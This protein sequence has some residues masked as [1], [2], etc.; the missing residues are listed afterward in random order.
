[1]KRF[2]ELINECNI[3]SIRHYI[4]KI[5]YLNKTK[6]KE[7]MDWYKE[8]SK[9]QPT[10]S[11]N[12]IYIKKMHNGYN[13]SFIE[14][15]DPDD[16]NELISFSVETIMFSDLFGMYAYNDKLKNEE[17]VVAVLR[18]NT[19]SGLYDENKKAFFGELENLMQ[20]RFKNIQNKI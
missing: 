6:L 15:D 20:E 5:F 7:Y 1:M 18:E 10:L 13:V 9:I 8:I 17:F 4:K 16:I 19:F 12:L 3:D 14:S 11:D 2:Y